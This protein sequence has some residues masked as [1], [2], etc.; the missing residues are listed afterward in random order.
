MARLGWDVAEQRVDG[1]WL[2][3]CDPA[4]QARY[5]AEL[6][7]AA[8]VWAGE[9]PQVPV[10][11]LSEPTQ[12]AL[13][14]AAGAGCYNSLVDTFAAATPE[15]W[16]LDLDAFLC[17]GARSRRETPDEQSLYAD[18]VRLSRPGR[19]YIATWLEATMVDV[20]D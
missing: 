19:E 15:V 4:Y 18:A 13:A 12:T 2:S 17:G 16:L 5:R 9:A 11:L 14:D 6:D 3:P 1:R 10:L 7:R 8:R 20:T